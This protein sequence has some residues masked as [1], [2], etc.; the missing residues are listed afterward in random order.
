MSLIAQ[1][2]KGLNE[3]MEVV[4]EVDERRKEILKVIQDN[5]GIR[6]S[7]IAD[8]IGIADSSVHHQMN[9]LKE[10]GLVVNKAWKSN[11]TNYE[12]AEDVEVR[13]NFALDNLLD[14]RTASHV[15]EIVLLGVAV[16]QAPFV[17]VFPWWFMAFLPT[18]IVTVDYIID[19]GDYTEINVYR[20]DEEVLED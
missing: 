18:F 15:L 9:K 3:K 5:P 17:D 16:T 12:L 8:E 7:D 6:S 10:D 2:F 1:Q 11:S 20:E 14:K 19:E 4:E 13:V